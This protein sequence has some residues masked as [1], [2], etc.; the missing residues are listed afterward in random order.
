MKSEQK[1]TNEYESNPFTLAVNATKR[2]F[3][4]N[5]G[6]AIFLLVLGVIGLFTGNN[7]SA[8]QPQGSSAPV[9]TGDISTQNMIATI[10]FIVSLVAIFAILVIVL[11]VYIQGIFSFVALQSEK[12]QKVTFSDALTAVNKRFWRLLGAQ[13]LAG[14][15]IFGWSL[16]FLIP[17][18]IAAFR[19]ALL[20]YV[21]MDESAEKHSVKESHDRV[22]AIT[23]SRLWE[24]VGVS[25]TGIV[26]VFGGLFDTAGKA[27]QYNQL[28]KYHDKK[29]EK[30]AIH[31]L[32]YV[33]VVFL[34][35][36]LLAIIV[37][38]AAVAYKNS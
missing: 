11:A 20:S 18:I 8:N 13:L 36:I 22:K 30:P 15:K 38:A 2:L 9:N 26:P 10:V 12:G 6:W 24:V 19:Y 3:D 1:K 17:G 37:I 5:R 29:L 31:W 16:L 33:M 35:F 25:T 14:V 4:T 27:A 21:V 7:R 32:N 28:A 23:K 34:V